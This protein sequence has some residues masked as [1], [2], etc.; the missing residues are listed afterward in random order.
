MRPESIERTNVPDFL[1]RFRR[2]LIIALHA[3]LVAVS[4][5]AAYLLRFEIPM[6]PSQSDLLLDSIAVVV[7]IK[8]VVFALFRLHEGLWRFVSLRDV[9]V[10]V[11]AATVSSLA[12]VSTYFLFGRTLPRSVVILDWMITIALVAGVRIGIRLLREGSHRRATQGSDRRRALVIGAGEAGERLVRAIESSPAPEYS[13]VGFVDDDPRLQRRSIRGIRVLGIVTSIP[14]LC[15]KHD[16]G[17]LLLAIPSA[18]PE[19]RQRIIERCRAAA[20]PVKTVPPFRELISGKHRIGQLQEVQPEYLLKRTAVDVDRDRL[21]EEVRGRTVLVTGAAGSIGSELAR[22]LAALGPERVVLVERSESTLYFV[23]LELSELFPEVELVPSVCD[24]QDAIRVGEVMARYRPHAVYHAAAYKHVP[25]MEDHPLSAI[26]NNVFGTEVVARAAAD[27]GA[28]RFVLIST[29]KAVRPVSVMGMTKRVAED[30]LRSMTYSS[31]TTFASVRFG[32]VLGSAGSVL[33]LFQWQMARGAPVTV[34]DPE[35]T[36]YFM[37]IAEAAQLVLQAGAVAT[38]GEV[39][40]LDMGEPVR[41]GDL[42][43]DLIRLSGMRPGE[44]VSVTTVGMRPGERLNEELIRGEEELVD[45]GHERILVATSPPLDG[46]AFAKDLE[47]LRFLTK[48]RDR[49]GAVEHLRAMA[50]R[51]SAI[52]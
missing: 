49:Q 13:V 5:A 24:I 37:L 41:I 19:E 25:L 15:A 45:S 38:G 18:S 17:T 44:E 48:N 35:A 8:M 6:P 27:A 32:N 3:A 34:T 14:E 4:Y 51:Y 22:Q 23:H 33:P 20:V 10:I 40:F 28:G 39:F 36:R 12:I 29:D 30:L 9:V 42:A 31:K 47:T 46:A 26:E 52:D 2:P 43:D 50:A 21:V 7:V 11:A 1:I 16:I